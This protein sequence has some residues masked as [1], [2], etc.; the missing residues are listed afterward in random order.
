M[1]DKGLDIG[2]NMLVCAEVGEDGSPVFK[3]QRDAFYTIV[4]KSGVNKSAIQVALDKQGCS[5][6]MDGHNFIVVGEDALQTAIERN[7]VAKRPLRKGVISPKEKASL[8]MLKYLIKELIGEGSGSDKIVYSVPAKPID[9]TYDIVYHTEIMNMYL[10]DMGYQ[11]TPLNEAYA[12]AYNE[13]IEDN[14]SGIAISWG[15][16]MVNIAVLHQ[17]DAL[18]EFSTTKSGDFIDMSVGNALD[19]SPSLI[20]LEKEAGVDLSNPINSNESLTESQ[21]V[22]SVKIKEAVSVYYSSVF[23]YT[24]ENIA[25]QLD[26][27][28][29]DLPMFREPI[30][31]VVSGGLSLAKGFVEKFGSVISR[32][33][34]P[35]KIS[36]I[37]KAENPMQAVA[38]GCLLASTI[39]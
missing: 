7:D 12:I 13:L 30:P 9:A 25:Y 6:I 1:G 32:V 39:L 27:R 2:T 14:L 11:A 24:L 38:G 20:Q 16:G 34:L 31:I 5:Y 10:R 22:L 23:N 26:Q 29:K 18:V 8:P 36:D 4:P 33:E 19:L 21:E 28:K 35:F 3:M 15:A 37:R 17:G